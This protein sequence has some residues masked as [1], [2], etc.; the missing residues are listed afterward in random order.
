M[1]SGKIK[2]SSDVQMK[3]KPFD[4]IVKLKKIEID[5][6]INGEPVLQTVKIL[7]KKVVVDNQSNELF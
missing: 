4:N 2:P 5:I 7:K 3:A 6:D 1:F